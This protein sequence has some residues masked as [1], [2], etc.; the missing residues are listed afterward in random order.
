MEEKRSEGIITHKSVQSASDMD[1]LTEL[2]LEFVIAFH[3]LKHYPF[4]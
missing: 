2:S 3:L 4:N 1:S